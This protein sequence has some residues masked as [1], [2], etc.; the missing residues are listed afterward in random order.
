MRDRQLWIFHHQVK[1]AI[2]DAVDEGL[3]DRYHIV[4]DIEYH[5]I[6]FADKAVEDSTSCSGFRPHH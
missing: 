5:S 3:I 6:N 1:G 2:L 4:K